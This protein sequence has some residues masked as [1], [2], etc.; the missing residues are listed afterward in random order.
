MYGVYMCVCAKIVLIENI[1]LIIIDVCGPECPPG[2]DLLP[3][4]PP[5]H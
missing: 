4:L 2:H 5:R 3:L 1:Y